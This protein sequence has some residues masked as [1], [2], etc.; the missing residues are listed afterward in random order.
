MESATI[1]AYEQN[2]N[3]NAFHIDLLM[4]FKKQKFYGHVCEVL[5]MYCKK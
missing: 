2:K 5:I 1:H 4:H 3:E